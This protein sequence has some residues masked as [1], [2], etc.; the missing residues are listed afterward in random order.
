MNKWQI[1][2]T[3]WVQEFILSTQ[4]AEQSKIKQ[5]I[6]L[7]A[8]YG[9]TLPNK[10]LKRLSGT[11]KLWEIRAKRARVFLVIIKNQ[12]ITVHGIFKKTQKTPKRDIDLALQR[13]EKAK[14]ELNI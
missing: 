1:I 12:G 4:P 3:P 8:E 5:I 9:P 2:I 13:W 11:K 6:L 14:K 7:F 10:Y